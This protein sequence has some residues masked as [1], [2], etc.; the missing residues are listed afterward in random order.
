MNTLWLC[1]GSTEG[2]IPF[3]KINVKANLTCM[4]YGILMFMEIFV[5]CNL[6]LP[7]ESLNQIRSISL[8][9]Y[10]EVVVIIE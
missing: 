8:M 7:Q 4:A 6:F 5:F 10:D 3:Q 1:A 9:K 2:E